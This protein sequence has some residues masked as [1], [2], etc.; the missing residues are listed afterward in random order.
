MPGGMPL[1]V[2]GG[3]SG[4][5]SRYKARALVSLMILFTLVQAICMHESKPEL[6]QLRDDYG[7]DKEV[8][9]D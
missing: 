1:A 5:N 7:D 9:F 4:P 2:L 3:S 6:Q 8:V